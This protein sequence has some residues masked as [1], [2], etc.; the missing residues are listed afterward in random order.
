MWWSE[1]AAG[2]HGESWN[3]RMSRDTFTIL[4]KE[5]RPHLEWK[6]RIFCNPVGVEVRVAV[7][8]WRFGTNVKFRTISELFV[9]GR[10]TV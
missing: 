6:R 8:I 5:L 3:F 1:A 10:S 9:L 4:C 7:T 2:A